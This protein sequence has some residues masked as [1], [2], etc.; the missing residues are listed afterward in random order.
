MMRL[1]FI[2]CISL[3]IFAQ[4]ALADGEYQKTRDGKTTVWNS[5]PK[6][7][8]EATWEGERDSEG[9]AKGFGTLSWYSTRDGKSTLF[10]RYFGNMVRGKFDGPVN[11]HAKNQTHY[12]IF[13]DG[14]RMTRWSGGPAPSRAWAKHR[15]LA[16]TKKEKEPEVPAE[17]PKPTPAAQKVAKAERAETAPAPQAKT[18][19]PQKAQPPT[20]SSSSGWSEP[21]EIAKAPAPT[22]S[23]ESDG[24][25][26]LLTGPPNALRD[27][28]PAPEPETAETQPRLTSAEVVDL[29]DG[30][31]RSHGLNPAEFERGEPHFN[32]QDETWSLNY[33]R[34]G[35]EENGRGFSVTIDDKTKGTVFVPAK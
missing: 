20:T 1:V 9:Y 24:S 3:A 28:P 23:A 27:I 14:S 11:V 10:A 15:A 33:G 17:G 16:A 7:G 19:A 12:A 13:V 22:K 18:K 32:A 35:G 26:Q 29:A 5:E 34:S 8:D 6:T 2:V 30:A 31:T 25:L 21:A 4:A